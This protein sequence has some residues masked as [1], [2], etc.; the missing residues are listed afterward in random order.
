MAQETATLTTP[1]DELF[2]G[3]YYEGVGRRKTT[4]ARVRLFPARSEGG[5]IIVNGRPYTQVFPRLLHQVMVRRPLE[6][7]GTLQQFNVS[8]KCSGGGVSGWAGAVSHGIARA[9]I[10]WNPE[11]KPILR[12]AGLV[13]RDPRVKERQKYGLKRARKAPQYSKR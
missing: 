3:T 8:V 7:T 12:R 10:E 4:V 11:L 6:V 13:T 9:L 5:H 1:Y 2:Q